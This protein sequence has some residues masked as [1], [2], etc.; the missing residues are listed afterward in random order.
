MGGER[1]VEALRQENA[2]LRRRLAQLEANE[3]TG[4]AEFLRS[5]LNALP[6]FVIR[7]G[8][9]LNIRYLN[10]Y[11]QGFEPSDTVGRSAFDY[12]APEHRAMARA[13][14]EE[15]LRTGNAQRY[16]LRAQGDHGRL[17]DYETI[18]APVEEADGRRGVIFVA[19]DITAQAERER[20]LAQSR[21]RLTLAVEA[22]GIGLWN[23]DSASNNVEWSERMHELMGRAEALDPESYVRVAVHPDDRE[24]VHAAMERA[25]AG[26][27]PRW[28]SHR[29][30]RPDGEI[31]WV[32][33]CASVI[34]DAEGKHVRII[35]GNLD[36]TSNHALEER[37]RQAERM[38]SLGTLTAGVAHNF[39]NL[40]S[41][42]R[43][44]LDLIAAQ[45]TD[46]ARA[47]HAD[48]VHATDRAA[49]V[50]RQ[51]MT[52]AGKRRT[53]RFEQRSLPELAAHA[54]RLCR[55]SF[56]VAVPI[57]LK[58]LSEP[59]LVDCEPGELEQVLVNLLINAR[60]ALIEARPLEPQIGVSVD[61]VDK[62]PDTLSTSTGLVSA[63]FAR[64]VVTD[65]GVGIE[66][67]I[68]KRVFD[69]FFSTKGPGRGTG[70]GLAMSWAVVRSIGGTIAC[71]SMLNRGT[72]F[73][74]Y[75]PLAGVGSSEPVVR[76]RPLPRPSALT[77]LLVEDDEY[78][79]RVIRRVLNQADHVTLE[80]STAAQAIEMADQHSEVEAILLDQS[81]PDGRGIQILPMLRRSLP[82]AK[83][84]LFTGE[85]VSDDDLKLV[86]GLLSKPVPS[87]RLLGTLASVRKSKS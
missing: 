54:V 3:V 42:I 18:M 12:M 40:L 61:I 32:M 73:S 78:V 58:V 29:I 38:E 65:N 41:V 36:V 39:N 23:W 8:P 14:V 5:L 25:R 83:V 45:V 44:S 13:H 34:E 55:R 20:A 53:S 71:D 43:A 51:L 64:V 60:D 70:L 17:T 4:D 76:P 10:R 75:L 11:A 62:L 1:D 2:E 28:I 21:A 74:V 33:P 35:G 80:A 84:F 49:E 59:P 87:E 81:L 79:R 6:A 37:L 66:E 30:V 15:V 46:E 56:G 82:R 24:A 31:R 22:T 26:E 16:Q 69:P 63:R 85:D 9:D 72:R 57:D 19:F 68:R 52:F 86:D 47:A 7:A 50:V 77:V 27:R 67:S 48:A